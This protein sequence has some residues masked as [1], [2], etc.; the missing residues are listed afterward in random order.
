MAMRLSL[1]DARNRTNELLEVNVK[2][3]PSKFNNQLVAVF[4]K[5]T[6]AWRNLNDIVCG[7]G[8]LSGI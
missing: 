5:N 6:M 2:I 7:Q 1:D 8:L 3:E 4:T